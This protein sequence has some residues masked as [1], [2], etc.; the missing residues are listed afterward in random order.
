V[1][2]VWLELSE[3]TADKWTFHR[4]DHSSSLRRQGLRGRLPGNPQ[5][6]DSFKLLMASDVLKME[7]P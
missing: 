7:P 3:A 1:D 2:R 4:E 5:S 6:I